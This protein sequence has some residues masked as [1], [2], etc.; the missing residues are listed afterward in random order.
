MTPHYHSCTYT[1]IMEGRSKRKKKIFRKDVI[2]KNYNSGT[3][4]IARIHVEWR[5]PKIFLRMMKTD[6]TQTR[7]SEIIRT[8]EDK[9]FEKRLSGN[10]RRIWTGVTN[11]DKQGYYHGFCLQ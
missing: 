2:G 9:F 6:I 8:T 1:V 10:I 7:A 11:N 3:A 5:K 4:V